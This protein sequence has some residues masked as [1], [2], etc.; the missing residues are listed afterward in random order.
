MRGPVPVV[1]PEV[2]GHN[3]PVAEQGWKGW[4]E[5]APFYDW[6]NAQTLGRRDVAF[7]RR[8]AKGAKGRVL[9][10]GCGTGRISLPLARAGI[11]IVGIDRS[12]PMLGRAARR[13]A[14][15]R[16]RKGV[17][18]TPA[19]GLTR[20]DIRTLPF[21]PG[22]F[23]MVL[24]PYGILQSLLRDKDLDATL[25]A[26]AGVLRPGGAFGVD[27]VPDVPQWREYRN[28]VQMRGRTAGGVHLTLVESVR[29]DRRRR[30][31]IFEQEYRARRGRTVTVHPF[32]LRFRTLPV[33]RMTE[34]LERAGFVI[35][36]VLGDYRG[37]PWDERADVWII[38]AEKV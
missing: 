26:V 10:L 20:G 21:L 16:K 31:T 19:L 8:V 9:E 23:G 2:P 18:R 15:L 37:R 35:R 28:R 24:A 33:R 4:D 6:E 25:D 17:P 12:E 22:S 11:P 34:R 5:Y 1:T 27:L 38:L 29:Q 3:L 32:T 7:W 30:L 14:L 36:A 13:R